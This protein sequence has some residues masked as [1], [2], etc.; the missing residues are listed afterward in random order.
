MRGSVF[1]VSETSS[2]IAHLAGAFNLPRGEVPV[3]DGSPRW[4]WDEPVAHERLVHVAKLLGLGLT[5]DEFLM[6]SG[7]N[8]AW[9]IGDR[10]V[11]ICWRG[12][13]DRLV[14][15]SAIADV[16]PANVPHAR[17]DD[18]GRDEALS[19]T[20]S[21][22]VAGTSLAD[23]WATTPGHQLRDLARQSAAMMRALHQWSA[24]GELTTTLRQAHQ[25]R[26]A[27][28]LA[29][30]GALGAPTR[31]DHQDTMIEFLRSTPFM[32]GDLLDAASR[33]I[34]TAQAAL[35]PLTEEDV[36]VHGDFTPG[37]ILVDKGEITA[38]LDFE[39]ARLAPAT[40]ESAMPWI[41]ISQQ[42]S[43]IRAE[44]FLDWLLE[45]YP[46]PFQVPDLAVR[47]EMAE[48]GFALRVCIV[49][50]PDRP[51]SDLTPAHPLHQLRRLATAP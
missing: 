29:L 42:P 17:V 26:E 30:V 10:V 21:P 28:A 35:A 11:R 9:R 33:R 2:E 38:V 16:L 7:S 37:N 3:I 34:Q 5:G 18:S 6:D 23:L 14:R 36:F 51:E 32:D 24:P 47:R 39:Y 46:E 31:H 12:D 45:D 25:P 20:V 49:W 27:D 8:D 15:E 40:D 48:F 1:A 13:I 4:P 44:R 41:W 43:N 22:R 50:P 19:W